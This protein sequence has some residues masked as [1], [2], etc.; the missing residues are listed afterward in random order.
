M[1]VS[2][3]CGTKVLPDTDL[4]SDCKEHCTSEVI[5]TTHV[6]KTYYLYGDI[7]LE[8]LVA[9]IP[10]LQKRIDWLEENKKTVFSKPTDGNTY[11]HVTRILEAQKLFTNMIEE[12]KAAHARAI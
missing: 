10:L 8:E 1:I 4:C 3:C 5:P 6:E 2:N 7:P 9:E 11:N 12:I